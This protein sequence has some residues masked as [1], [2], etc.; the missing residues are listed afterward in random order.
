MKASEIREMTDDELKSQEQ[1]LKRALQNLR[2]QF[3]TGQ[4][5]NT[6]QLKLSKR[7]LARVKTVLKERGLKAS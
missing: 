5:T 6:A 1:E 4:L 2:I 3:A 7:D